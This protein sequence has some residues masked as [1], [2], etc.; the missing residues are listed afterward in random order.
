[1]DNLGLFDAIAD[2]AVLLDKAGRIINWNAGAASLFGYAKKEVLGRS[3][4]FIYD[5][6]F[7]FPK[8]IQEIHGN[9]KKWHEETN[10][11]RKNGIKGLCKSSLTPITFNEQHKLMALLLHHN[12]S[13]YKKVKMPCAKSTSKCSS[14]YS[15]CCITT[16]LL[17][18]Y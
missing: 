13:D 14:I 8:L 1:M 4:N 17:T 3:I 10:Y 16:G 15:K 5:R 11:I 12:L 6:N 9:Q 7:P 2:S 18:A